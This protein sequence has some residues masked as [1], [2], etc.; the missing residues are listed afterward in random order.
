MAYKL[1]FPY[2]MEYS[3][4]EKTNWKRFLEVV[5]THI[6]GKQVEMEVASLDIGDQI[7]E[8][9]TRIR[10]ISFDPKK[11]VLFIH[12]DELD[13]MIPSPREIVV[14]EEG[15]TI[16]KSISIKSANDSVEIIQFR[17]PLLLEGPR[18]PFS[19]KSTGEVQN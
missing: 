5:A 4:I 2:A 13:H 8:N 15:G 3:I 11:N 1:Q 17:E 7:V 9:W 14:G 10:G 19:V 18:S 16:I 12:T 6:E